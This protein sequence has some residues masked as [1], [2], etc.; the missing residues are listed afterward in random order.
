MVQRYGK[1]PAL[2]KV[3]EPLVMFNC[4]IQA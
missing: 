4:Q 3:K 2:S 1:L